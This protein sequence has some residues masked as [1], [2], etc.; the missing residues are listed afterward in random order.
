MI[1]HNL[2]QLMTEKQATLQDLSHVSGV[3]CNYIN[4][5]R[6]G[7]EIKDYWG[8]C[9]LQALNNAEFVYK[10]KGRPEGSKNVN[11]YRRTK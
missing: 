1:I 4:A 2:K 3:H 8:E 6:R 9:L 7:D 11:P 10:K 5:A